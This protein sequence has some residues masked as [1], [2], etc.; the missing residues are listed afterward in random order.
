MRRGTSRKHQQPY[1]PEEDLVVRALYAL[2]GP[3]VCQLRLPNRTIASI[4]GRAQ[5]LGITRLGPK[6]QFTDAEVAL[7]RRHYRAL[8]PVGCSKLMPRKS[9]NQIR[10]K[11]QRMGIRFRGERS[12]AKRPIP[13]PECQPRSEQ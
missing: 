2:Y 4:A 6:S 7:L 8:G 3:E 11:A 9:A 5:Y 10:C 13:T 1:R 12:V